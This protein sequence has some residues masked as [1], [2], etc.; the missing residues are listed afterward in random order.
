MTTNEKTN[1]TFST[2]E[3]TDT[4]CLNAMAGLAN[5]L[6]L[7]HWSATIQ[8][9]EHEA[10]CIARA[11]HEHLKR[12]LQKDVPSIESQTISLSDRE[13]DVLRWAALGKST[14]VT[15]QILRISEKTVRKARETAAQKLDCHN[16][17]QSVVA[18]TRL[19]LLER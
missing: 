17:T 6:G 15:A 14:S 3:P 16:I 2:Q 10:I 11:F 1:P 12:L 19:G 9:K 18:A 7:Q 8:G 4:A 13:L 5:Q